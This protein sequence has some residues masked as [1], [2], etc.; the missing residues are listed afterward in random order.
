MGAKAVSGFITH[1]VFPANAWQKFIDDG[2]D[3]L[4]LTDSVPETT[5]HLQGVLPVPAHL[6]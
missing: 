2:W 4:Y 1:A 6:Q 3:T 5:K